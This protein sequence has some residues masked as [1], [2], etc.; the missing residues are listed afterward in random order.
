[1]VSVLGEKG[2]LTMDLA[3]AAAPTLNVQTASTSERSIEET[4][5][6]SECSSALSQTLNHGDLP[7]VA[8]VASSSL[9]LDGPAPQKTVSRCLACRKRVGLVGFK[10]RCGNVFC[11][12]HR[13]SD[14]HDCSFDYKAA[15]RDAIAKANPLV[16][17]DKVEKI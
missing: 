7:V 10:C 16:K 12:Q 1:M 4:S 6:S 2:L 15:A 14:Q 11:S 3:S 17:A 8:S 9:K 5:V 13:Y